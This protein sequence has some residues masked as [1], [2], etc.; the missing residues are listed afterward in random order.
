MHLD[1][2]SD[3]ADAEVERLM[4][5]GAVWVRAEDDPADT[6][7]VVRDPEGNVLRLLGR[8]AL[9]AVTLRG[10]LA[11][12]AEKDHRTT[13]SRCRC[14]VPRRTGRTAVLFGPFRVM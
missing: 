4:G 1:L 6:Y 5:L 10:D 7:V 2:Y 3:D 8:L 11:T 12:L 9:R 13:S 14:T